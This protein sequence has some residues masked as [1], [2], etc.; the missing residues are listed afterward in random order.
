MYKKILKQL[1]IDLKVADN[2]E[3]EIEIVSGT[4][5]KLFGK[6]YSG[7][8]LLSGHPAHDFYFG[9]YYIKQLDEFYVHQI[10]DR[11]SNQKTYTEKIPRNT[12]TRWLQSRMIE[13]A[14]EVR[15]AG[16]S[17]NLILKGLK[18]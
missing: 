11:G 9:I 8:C 13:A 17:L 4:F 15:S 12:I 18:A 10:D 7:S 14:N 3:I 16:Y 2:S 6:N 1:I 5:N